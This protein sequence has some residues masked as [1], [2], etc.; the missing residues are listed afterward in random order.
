M[1]IFSFL[2]LAISTS[3][4]SNEQELID[5]KPIYR[6]YNYS[7]IIPLIIILIVSILY[8]IIK[9][10][11]KILSRK[12]IQTAVQFNWDILLRNLSLDQNL[13][14]KEIESELIHY[15]KLYLDN[16]Y[17]LN[18]ISKIDGEL[19]EMVKMTAK[20]NSKQKNQIEEFLDGSEILR[21]AEVEKQKVLASNRIG[22]LREIIFYGPEIKSGEN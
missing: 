3:L 7:I 12:K 18:V 10:Y 16:R 19:I 11:K 5:L 15:L 9:G 8:L 14:P 2:I 13:K 17:G 20:I 4:F 6:S 21:F 1:K 22:Q